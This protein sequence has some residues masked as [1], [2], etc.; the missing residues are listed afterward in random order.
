MEQR[1]IVAGIM[2][3]VIIAAALYTFLGRDDLR[4]VRE[5]RFFMDT[6]VEMQ[7][8][9]EEPETIMGEAFEAMLELEAKTDRF[10]PES[11]VSKINE[12]AGK[13]PVQVD[14]EV[15][16]IIKKG[17]EWGDKTDGLFTIAIA[18]LM[19]L[20]G[21][22]YD[23]EPDLPDE[24]QI[25]AILPRISLDGIGVFPEENKIE[26]GEGMEIDLGGIAKGAVVDR[27]ME[28]LKEN[29]VYGAFINAG[30]DIRVYGQKEDRTSW[31][32]GI[33]DPRVDERQHLEDFIVEAEKGA[34]VTSG[35][36]ERYFRV[37]G[38]RFHHI[39]DPRTG[40]PARGLRSATIIGPS[41]AVADVLSTAAF[42]MGE[43]ALN[44][45]E[46][47]PEYEGLFITDNGEILTTTNFVEAGK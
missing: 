31:R 33:R 25:E 4:R 36:Y 7:V 13:G 9:H 6:V 17:L 16:A 37:D 10:N 43:N 39:L 47:I 41:C 12:S 2:A 22:G 29:G 3:L 46:E 28:V 19:D 18:P 11:D 8:V 32:V 34:I 27:G 35:D 30:G 24:K 1:K 38:E 44:F 23:Q 15:M 5:T 26:I 20:W 14:E 45:V 42:M 21:F 40:Y